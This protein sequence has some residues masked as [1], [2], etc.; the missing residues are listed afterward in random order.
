MTSPKASWSAAFLA[1][2]LLVQ[3]AS[4]AH[5]VTLIQDT[6]TGP[7]GSNVAGTTP[8]IVGSP[9][10]WTAWSDSPLQTAY[11]TSPTPGAVSLAGTAGASAGNVIAIGSIVT[12]SSV[13]VSADISL[14]SSATA[15]GGI[16]LAGD[17]SSPF[18][19]MLAFIDSNGSVQL[20]KNYAGS[21][22]GSG[23]ISGFSLTSTYNLALEYNPLSATASVYVNGAAVISN[24]AVG[25]LVDTVSK[26][27]F[28]GY[29]N[30][31]PSGTLDNF[32]VTAVPEPSSAAL[33]GAM[34]V[35]AIML[36][37]RIAAREI[38]H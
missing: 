22:L 20:Y 30:G 21:N 26:A 33:L 8:S 14:G 15:F 6:F 17:A 27:G 1:M 34:G 32:T 9:T 37:R 3:A 25:S 19:L 16:N 2:G 24:V 7:A 4:P 23:S 18:G 13:T 10:Q 38:K 11:I 5:A 36:R 29:E 12:Y 28:M 31:L 35:F